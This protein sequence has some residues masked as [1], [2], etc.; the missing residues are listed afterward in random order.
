MDGKSKEHSVDS[1][2]RIRASEAETTATQ[3]KHQIY[4]GE[5][6]DR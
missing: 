5:C 6:Y 4:N 2:H 3:E 1:V